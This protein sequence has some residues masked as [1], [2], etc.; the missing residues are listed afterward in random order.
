[1]SHF[2]HECPRCSER[3]RGS[4]RS[5]LFHIGA[6]EFTKLLPRDGRSSTFLE[7]ISKSTT[8]TTTICSLSTGVSTQRSGK[9]CLRIAG[10]LECIDDTLDCTSA[11]SVPEPSSSPLSKLRSTNSRLTIVCV[12]TRS[13]LSCAAFNQVIEADVANS[14]LASHGFTVANLSAM[15]LKERGR[16]CQGVDLDAIMREPRS[17]HEEVRLRCNRVLAVAA[18]RCCLPSLSSGVPFTTSNTR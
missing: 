6:C 1:M 17:A 15:H 13:L 5:S 16:C 7:I 12:R 8:T 14:H 11:K 10:L 18:S 9:C 3:L 4:S 2:Q